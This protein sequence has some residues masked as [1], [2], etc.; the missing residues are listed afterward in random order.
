VRPLPIREDQ[1]RARRSATLMS[2]RRLYRW[3]VNVDRRR[4]RALAIVIEI[5]DDVMMLRAC[6]AGQRQPASGWQRA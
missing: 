5:S 2:L 1:V 3:I 4:F 6:L